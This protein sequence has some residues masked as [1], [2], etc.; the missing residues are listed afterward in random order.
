MDLLDAI[1]AVLTEA[2]QPLGPGAIWER[3]AAQRLWVTRGKT[4]KATVNTG[5]SEDIRKK[6]DASRFQRVGRGLYVARTAAGRRS[7][8]GRPKKMPGQKHTPMSFLD[9]AE[10]VLRQ[11][12]AS[13]MHYQAITER[14]LSAGLIHTAGKTSGITLNSALSTDI[15]RRED[16]GEA[17]RFVRVKGGVFGLARVPDDVRHLIVKQNGEVRARL[18]ARVKEVTADDFEEL[19]ADLLN[20]MGFADVERTPLSGD[21]GI[22]VRGTLVVGDVVSVRMAVQAKR[23]Q[24]N[25][26]APTVQQVRGSLAV[27]EQGLIITT[28]DFSKGAR[29]EAQSTDKAP[30]ALMNGEQLASLLARYEMM[31]VERDQQALLTLGEQ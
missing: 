5:L 30:M 21:G 31:G 11:V 20:N 1:H 29:E 25:V 18:L 15:R 17:P 9:A 6:G 8:G 3:I 12:G 7:S 26:S 23:W 19:I 13:A 27:H 10:H 28:S 4:P 22:D 16:R 24:A 2:G 14:A